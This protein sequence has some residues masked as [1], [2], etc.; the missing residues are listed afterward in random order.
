MFESAELTVADVLMEIRNN[1]RLKLKYSLTDMTPFSLSLQQQ[2]PIITQKA[3]DA[4]LPFS[5]LYLCKAGISAMNMM[6]SK[7]RSRL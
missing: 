6:K 2:Y 3:T 1:R 4:L 7:N 5:A